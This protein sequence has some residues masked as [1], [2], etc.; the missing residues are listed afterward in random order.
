[1]DQMWKDLLDPQV[2]DEE[3]KVFRLASPVDIQRDAENHQSLFLERQVSVARH[4]AEFQEFARKFFVEENEVDVVRPLAYFSGYLTSVEV[5]VL[6]LQPEDPLCR[7]VS[8]AD[9]DFAILDACGE[10]KTKYQALFRPL[11]EG[12]ASDL[13]KRFFHTADDDEGADRREMFLDVLQNFST[14]LELSEA[15]RDLVNEGADILRVLFSHASLPTTL[16]E[17]FTHPVAW[18]ALRQ[19]LQSRLFWLNCQELQCLVACCSCRLSV[20]TYYGTGIHLC[21]TTSAIIDT[22]QA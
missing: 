7:E 18:A 2:Q 12:S 22:C 17:S 3:T 6:H 10:G 16:P 13:R 15:N 4:H 21:T 1:M 8:N 14:N 9:D 19:A 11:Q 20:H 5:D